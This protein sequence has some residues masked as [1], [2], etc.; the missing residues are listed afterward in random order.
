MLQHTWLL[1]RQSVSTLHVWRPC[2]ADSQI[3]TALESETFS[4]AWPIDVMQSWS[5]PQ[6]LGQLLASWHTLPAEP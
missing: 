1:P 4:H 3:V 5:L 6:N 2:D